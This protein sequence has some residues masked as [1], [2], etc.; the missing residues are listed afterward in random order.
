MDL[1]KPLHFSNIGL[2]FQKNLVRDIL[3]LSARSYAR[4]TTHRHVA[5]TFTLRVPSTVTT[6]TVD[7]FVDLLTDI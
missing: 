5:W 7:N 4:F 1:P 2:T 3:G 6:H